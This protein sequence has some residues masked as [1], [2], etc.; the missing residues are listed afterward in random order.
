MAFFLNKTAQQ[1]QDTFLK[2]TTT[3]N[4]LKNNRAY[5]NSD[6][7]TYINLC[8]LH[9]YGI[10]GLLRFKSQNSCKWAIFFWDFP[11][12][13]E[14]FNP[15][16]QTISL[17]TA[18]FICARLELPEELHDTRQL[19]SKLLIW[20]FCRWQFIAY[21]YLN[22]SPQFPSLFGFLKTSTKSRWLNKVSRPIGT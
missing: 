17:D 16:G 12:N 11:L 4:F 19:R 9:T 10:M 8:V 15:Q 2:D 13:K 22:I 21:M 3:H 18:T 14:A 6:H 20:N 7:S 1:L 5:E